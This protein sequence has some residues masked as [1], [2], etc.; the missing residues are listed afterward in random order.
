VTVSAQNLKNL[1]WLA[2]RGYNILSVTFRATF[3]GDEETLTG[4]FMPVLWE[5]LA[6]PIITGRDELG[7]PKLWAEM[8]DIERNGTSA[9]ASASWMG[10]RFAEVTVVDLEP[11]DVLVPPM[12]P[13]LFYK[14]MP[15]T[16]A[17]G[18]ADASYVTSS[19]PKPGATPA[20][21]TMPPPTVKRWSGKGS[22]SFNQATWQQL[23]TLVSIV[24]ALADLDPIEF[25]RATLTETTGADMRVAGQRIIH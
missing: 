11:A 24:N 15:K 9:D 1:W 2:G 19:A 14:Y 3:R 16:G 12:L 21:S 10:F 20:P 25:V 23:P 18:E 6:D 8:D 17:W 5:S 4:N 22:A 7:F 13:S